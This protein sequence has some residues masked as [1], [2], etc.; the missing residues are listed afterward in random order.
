MNSYQKL[1]TGDD[2]SLSKD[3]KLVKAFVKDTVEGVVEDTSPD[4]DL[5]ELAVIIPR[6]IDRVEEKQFALQNELKAMQSLNQ[7]VG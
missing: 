2:D 1:V 6:E 7:I 5:N 3:I 4:H